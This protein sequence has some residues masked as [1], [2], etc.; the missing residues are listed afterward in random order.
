MFVTHWL[1]FYYSAG[2]GAN[3]YG[4]SC[5]ALCSKTKEHCQRMV[6]CRPKLGCN[7]ASGLK[8]ILCSTC[9]YWSE[10]LI[11]L[12]WKV[13]LDYFKDN[14]SVCM[15]VSL[16]FKIVVELIQ[17]FSLYTQ[18]TSAPESTLRT[19]YNMKSVKLTQWLY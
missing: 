13:L 19:L 3:R 18:M 1:L 7:C 9:E 12:F 10:A 16:S 6:L 17:Q 8:G 2:C 5:E 14:F 4:A 15:W 11:L